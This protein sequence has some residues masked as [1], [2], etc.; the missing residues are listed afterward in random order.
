MSKFWTAF[1][2][3]YQRQNCNVM[4]NPCCT[5]PSHPRLPGAPRVHMHRLAQPNNI[6][7]NKIMKPR[8]IMI[9]SHEV[10]YI[11]R[12]GFFCPVRSIKH[13]EHT[14]PLLSSIHRA[15]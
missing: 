12:R 14:H 7:M 6:Y 5:S 4:P 3:K 8:Q 1:E 11:Y 13:Y 2:A 15:R 10:I 9:S